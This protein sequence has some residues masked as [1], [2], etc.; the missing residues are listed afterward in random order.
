ME[1]LL[2]GVSLL[3]TRFAY[4]FFDRLLRENPRA[5]TYEH[6]YTHT[7]TVRGSNSSDEEEPEILRDLRVIQ[8]F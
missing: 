6:T 1:R 8:G 4:G 7:Q 3:F 5:Y 2:C